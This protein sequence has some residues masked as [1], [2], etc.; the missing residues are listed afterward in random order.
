MKPIQNG[1][2]LIEL[3]VVVVIIGI[4]AAIAIPNLIAA[5]R[6]ANEGSAISSIRVLHNAEVMYSRTVGNGL[7]TSSLT[8]LRNAQI[9]DSVLGIGVKS[10]YSFVIASSIPQNNSTFTVGGV[11]T[12]SSGEMKTGT[13]KFC[14]ATEGI[15][16]NE[17]SSALIGTNISNDGDCI[18][19]NYSLISE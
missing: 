15:L 6:A 4:L 12:T 10:G 8:D 18:S 5:R 2:S 11:P 7:F 1:F 3:L 17:N 19:S 9:I 14:I 13:R 16:R